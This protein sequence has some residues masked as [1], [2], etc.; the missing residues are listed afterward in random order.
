[1]SLDA[2]IDLFLFLPL[3]QLEASPYLKLPEILLSQRL[4]STLFLNETNPLNVG[5]ILCDRLWEGQSHRSAPTGLSRRCSLCSLTL[6]K[7]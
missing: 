3:A 4:C 7:R 2:S 1:M 6:Q 5:A